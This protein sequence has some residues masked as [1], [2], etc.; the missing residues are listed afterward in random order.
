MTES[1]PPGTPQAPPPSEPE[2]YGPAWEWRGQ[3]GAASALWTTFREV[4]FAPSETF[5]LARREGGLREPYLY[6]LAMGMFSAIAGFLISFPLRQRG[7]EY[8][9]EMTQN[10]PPRMQRIYERFETHPG[11]SFTTTLLAIL[12]FAPI[13]LTVAVF[14]FSGINHLFMMLFGGARRGFETTFRAT[15]YAT[16][17]CAALKIIP[18][19]V[20]GLLY[21][22]VMPIILIIALAEMHETDTWR[23]VA[24]VAAPGVILGCCIGGLLVIFA[25]VIYRMMGIG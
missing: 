8:M 21:L 12:V 18:S 2:Q 22:V 3:L 11:W 5:R 23:A 19:C 16:G 25:G 10:L 1:I 4:V 24:A 20:G 7:I 13:A 9:A 17:A 14:V 6:C 15:A